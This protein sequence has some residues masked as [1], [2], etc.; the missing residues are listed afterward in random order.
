MSPGRRPTASSFT[1]FVAPWTWVAVAIVAAA[2]AGCASS[3]MTCPAGQTACGNV[4]V[5]LQACALHCGKCEISCNAGASCNAGICECP[6]AQPD[7]C[8]LK[9]V[10]KQT[11]AANCGTCGHD[12][13]R[14]TCQAAACVCSP[15]PSTVTICPPGAFT[16]GT[17]VDT[18]TSGANCGACASGCVPAEVCSASTCQCLSPNTSCPGTSSAV[19]TNTSTDSRNCG[20]CGI[21]C[22]AGQTCSSSNCVPTCEA[23]FTPCN[24]VC[25][26][27]KNDAAHCG[28]CTTACSSGQTCSAS[29]CKAACPTLKCGGTCCADLTACCGTFCPNRHQNFVGTPE[30]QTYHDCT[31]TGTYDVTTAREAA[32]NWAP[33]G[34]LISSAQSCPTVGGGSL[35]VIWQKPLVGLD[36][37]CGVWCYAGPYAGTLSV[38]QSYACPCP[39][40]LGVDWD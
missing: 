13:G 12:C 9:C 27:L 7:T 19:C 36:V 30:V 5:D 40:A 15:T 25:V 10:N 16:T 22:P 17:C 39:T 31:P 18:A 33:S 38:T 37:G 34:N 4:C 26:D 3:G 20:T 21:V 1:R 32:R 6:A 29:T 35:C 28:S 23:G 8:G 11:D 24:G 14:G 2:G